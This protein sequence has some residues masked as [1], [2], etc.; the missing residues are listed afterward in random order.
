MTAGWTEVAAR[1]GRVTYRARRRPS[2]VVLDDP[3]DDPGLV[4]LRTHDLDVAT[5]LAADWWAGLSGG[6][7][8]PAHAGWT[9]LVPWGPWGQSGDM[10]WLRLGPTDR[11]SIPCVWFSDGDTGVF[12]PEMGCSVLS[13]RHSHL[14][15]SD[16]WSTG[17]TV[18]YGRSAS[19]LWDQSAVTSR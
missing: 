7:L 17:L 9:K 6:C 14:V 5:Y 11:G 19:W 13:L 12:L 16:L 3:G 1:P 15:S 18:G 4:V 2:V 10:T 8:P